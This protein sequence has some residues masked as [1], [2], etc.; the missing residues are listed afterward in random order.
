MRAMRRQVSPERKAA[1]YVGMVLSVVGLVVFLSTFVTFA[2]HFG[3]P[4]GVMAM[5]GS[6]MVRAIGGM[7][8]MMIGGAVMGIGRK[9]LA[10]A[11]VVL[12][13]ERGRRDLEPF[14][15]QAGGMLKDALDEADIHL[16]GRTDKVVVIKC[17]ECGKLNEDD[18]KFCQECGKPL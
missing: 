2:T 7:I 12:D 17:R 11:G 1:Y 15:R 14:T 4:S 8:L 13:P 16:G 18:S 6:M 9:G 3:D 5:S 10:G